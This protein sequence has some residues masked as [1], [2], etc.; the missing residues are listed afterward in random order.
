MGELQ[1]EFPQGHSKLMAEL[2]LEPTPH[3]PLQSDSL[4]HPVS[5]QKAGDHVAGPHPTI[6]HRTPRTRSQEDSPV[7]GSPFL[8]LRICEVASLVSVKVEPSSC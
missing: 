6:P 8:N 5:P 4:R 3:R 2:S 1:A 7:P